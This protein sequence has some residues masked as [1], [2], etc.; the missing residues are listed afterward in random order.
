VVLNPVT[1]FL[2]LSIQDI[3]KNTYCSEQGGYKALNKKFIKRILFK[4]GAVGNLNIR[5]RL[6]IWFVIVSVIP[7]IVIGGFSYYLI[8]E[9]ISR[10]NEET[11]TNIN[12]GIYNMVDT[13]QKVLNR[14]LDSSAAFLN[15]WLASLGQSRFDYGQMVDA[16]GYRLPTWYIGKQ[17]MTDDF[18]VVDHLME[19]ESLGCSF[20]QFH[21][22][23]F[24]RIS[25]NVRK[26]NGSRIM[27]TLLEQPGPIYD[28]LINGQIYV[29]RANVEGEMWA[30]V[31]QP[32]RDSGGKM[33]G[34]YALGR[35][36]QEYELTAAIKNIVVGETGYV[37]VLDPKGNVIIHPTL[38]GKN[39][40]QYPF[41]QEILQK[42]NG[43]ITYD[44]EGRKKIAHYI[45]Y[46]PWN[47]Y[48]V[49]GSYESEIFNITRGLFRM[50]ILTMLF[51]VAISS[52]IAF[53]LSTTFSRPINQLMQVM[54]QAQSGNLAVKFNY[55]GNDEFRILSNA[56][57]AMLNNISLLIG[58]ILTNATKLKEAS[59]QLI[60]D[61]SE[62]KRSLKGIAG[63]VENMRHMH[64]VE[65]PYQYDPQEYIEKVRHLITELKLLHDEGK[66]EI[67]HGSLGE[68]IK[69]LS[70]IETLHHDAHLGAIRDGHPDASVKPSSISYLNNI[71]SMEVEVHKL[72][73]LLKNICSSASSLDG[74]ALSLD[75]YVNVFKV[76]NSE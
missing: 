41:V 62:S 9:K 37:F 32:L 55:T 66:S 53:V 40:L 2:H 7:I 31:Y 18:T 59:Q 25:T 3:P 57:N 74:I 71:S 11:I 54:R 76:E 6:F 63:N 67:D 72:N 22:N 21:D 44:W 1:R 13:Q 27:Y 5:I 30:T 19:K 24:I 46:E 39:Y 60:I 69:T 17:K 45:F 34:A 20:F 38:Q 42:K 47:W 14:W 48:I 65:V 16:K 36:E 4:L 29:G 43:F 8:F 64:I 68:A 33:I 28:R 10:Q 75:R 70:V 35:R 73:L 51:A 15:N 58:R 23:K 61:I 12:R 52:L 50:L 49:T 56:F 26:P